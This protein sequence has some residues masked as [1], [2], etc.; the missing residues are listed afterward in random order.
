MLA[1]GCTTVGYYTEA[2]NGHY[3]LM[4]RRLPV[5]QILAQPDIEPALREK[6][7]LAQRARDF[8]SQQLALP[9]NDSYRS[10]A[11]LERPFA[12]WNVVATDVFS[13]EPKTW[14]FMFAGCINY[15]GYFTQQKAEHYAES[16]QQQGMDTFVAGARAY[17]T[18]GWFADP[19]LNTMLDLEEARLVGI[20]FHELAHQMLY[21]KDDSMFNESFATTIEREGIR[22]WFLAQGEQTAYDR[23]RQTLQRQAEF[24]RLLDTARQRLTDLYARNIPDAEKQHGKTSVFTQLKTDY[25]DLRQGWGDYDGYDR[26]FE[27][28]VN[29]ARLALAAT[30]FEYVPAF[31]AMLHEAESLEE[32]YNAAK[33]ISA[34]DKEQ[35]ETRLRNLATRLNQN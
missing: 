33:T 32:F 18:L 6:L 29:N 24:T 19:L 7:L 12:V 20:I 9:D 23:Y 22:R 34:L 3:D 28:P 21:V 1:S 5:E 16:L 8:A 2:I 25:A 27:K 17:S 14:C 4:E 35:R 10:Y 11:D 15:R 26:W 30:Y 13:V 31:T